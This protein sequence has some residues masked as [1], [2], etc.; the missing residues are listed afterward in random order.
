MLIFKISIPLIASWFKYHQCKKV[1]AKKKLPLFSFHLSTSVSPWQSGNSRCAKKI[2]FFFHFVEG[3]HLVANF[4]G[5]NYAL[6]QILALA[7]CNRPPSALF[8]PCSLPSPCSLFFN[9]LAVFQVWWGPCVPSPCSLFFVKTQRY[10]RV[11][12]W[13]E[14][15]IW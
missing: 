5:G 2:I 1:R 3:S 6:C 10:H 8:L 15:Q 12:L 4:S 11:W 13:L 7:S 14:K 9:P